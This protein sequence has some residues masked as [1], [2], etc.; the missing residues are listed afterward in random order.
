MLLYNWAIY[1][2]TPQVDFNVMSESVTQHVNMSL[3]RLV[4][5]F[6]TMVQ[7]LAN[8]QC[9]Q[10]LESPTC[11]STPQ[12]ANEPR[13]NP[14]TPSSPKP[15]QPPAKSYS[16][17]LENFETI[18]KM[19][20]GKNVKKVFKVEAVSFMDD[21]KNIPKCWQNLYHLLN[22]YNNMVDT[23]KPFERSP[24]K[25]SSCCFC[26]CYLFDFGIF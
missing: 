9:K 24:I 3:L 19:E 18:D 6:T 13:L 25:H 4:H 17:T 21:A 1:S 2:P 16:P 7:C 22:L 5:Q 8:S 11:F 26:C 23:N 15:Y 20:K 14:F 12:S 10:A